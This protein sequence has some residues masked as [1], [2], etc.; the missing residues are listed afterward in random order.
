MPNVTVKPRGGW[1]SDL[2]AEEI[3]PQF[4][5]RARNVLVRSGALGRA[6]PFAP[7]AGI[8]TNPAPL[9]LSG[10]RW[11]IPNQDSEGNAFW[12][13]ATD[14][15][16]GVTD[17]F[18]HEEITW[19]GFS[20]HSGDHQ[21][22][23]GGIVNQLPV[24]N[25]L[26]DGPFYWQQDFA[27]PGAMIALP[28]WPVGDL[29]GSMRPFREFLIAMDL[30]VGGEEFADLLRWSDAAPPGDVPQSWTPG[31]QSQAGE[32]SV[33][34]NPGELVDGRQLLDRFYVYKTQSVYVLTLV[35]GLFVFNNRPVF[36]SFGALTR[37]CVAEW[38][39]SHIVL[40][41]GDLV[42]HDGL[43]VR[44]IANERL[45]R[46]IFDNLS[47]EFFDNAYI[48]TSP[49]FNLL[50]VCRP[51]DGEQYPSEAIMLDLDDLSF[52]HQSLVSTGVPHIVDGLADTTQTLEP[53]WESKTTQW[54]NDGTRWG[55]GAFLRIE[56]EVI[57][58]DFTGS[59][60]QQL[61]LGVDQD[62]TA[63]DAVAERTGLTLGDARRRK[64]VRRVFPRFYG[65]SGTTV[66]V[67]IGAHDNPNIEPVYNAEQAFR[68]DTDR[69][70]SV[71]V[72]GFYLAY[73]FR[74]EDGLPWRLPSFEVEFE[75]MGPY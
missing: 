72:S 18:A 56:N 19:A 3:P 17:G 24:I 34:F 40:T 52:G 14:S 32:I 68:I 28:D 67:S 21:P 13:Y 39:G 63:I 9:T 12:V 66:F 71:D 49:R 58:A 43:N 55:E 30:I 62:G 4:I 64:F 37:G 31:L 69:Q 25:S 1:S 8:E 16:V 36:S 53:T 47:G 59:K 20:D 60:L 50:M 11:L 46:E 51:R 29:A 75:L 33:S 6:F 73:R 48:A 10:P 61:G 38:K 27:T 42:I 65:G 44:S 15:L 41:D 7:F 26:L 57:M 2:P 5:N 22:F 74:T 23:T 54:V 35:G 45:R 70:L